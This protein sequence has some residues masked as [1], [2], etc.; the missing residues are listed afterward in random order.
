MEITTTCRLGRSAL[1]AAFLAVVLA[2]PTLPAQTNA[3][4]GAAPETDP[5]LKKNAPAPAPPAG[6]ISNLVFT[7]EIYTTS[8]ADGAAIL[9]GESSDQVR[10]Q[11]V[12]DLVKAGKATFD[13]VLAASCVSGGQAVIEDCILMNFP[14]DWFIVEHRLPITRAYKGRNIGRRLSYNGDSTQNNKAVDFSA[15]LE[16]TTLRSMLGETLSSGGVLS[17][18][19]FDAQRLSLGHVSL[20]FGRMSFLGT[21]TSDATADTSTTLVFGRMDFVALPSAPAPK[22]TPGI[23]ENQFSFYSMSR[24]Q[25]DAVLRQLPQP[26]S[27]FSAV[28]ALVA[29]KEAKLEHVAAIRGNGDKGVAYEVCEFPYPVSFDSVDYGTQDTGFSAE[30]ATK[31]IGNT[32][33]VSVDVTK[34][35]WLKYRGTLKGATVTADYGPGPCFE[36][37]SLV[38]SIN[39]PLGENE[40]VGTISPPGDVGLTGL[41]PTGRV[42]LAFVKTTVASP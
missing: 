29:Q 33:L 39:A 1:A 10:Y 37:Q 2:A 34:L 13:D 11:R 35:Q 24:D 22:S 21:A 7:L 9:Q 28:Q 17:H 30:V 26:G 27:V 31:F 23:L 5:F 19:Q 14:I 6:P 8:Q 20:P 25:A 42:W 36:I 41:K 15:F 3:A 38:T 12:L 40:F 4:P 18:P 16:N 32:S